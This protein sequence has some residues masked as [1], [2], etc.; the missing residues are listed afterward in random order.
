MPLVKA[1]DFF[2]EHHSAHRGGQLTVKELR[3]PIAVAVIDGPMV[4]AARAAAELH[5][6]PTRWVRAIVRRPP[7]RIGDRERRYAPDFATVDIVHRSI[8]ESYL[9]EH[10][11]PY[12]RRFFTALTKYQDYVLEGA[13]RGRARHRRCVSAAC[14]L[15]RRESGTASSGIEC[16]FRK[17]TPRGG[18]GSAAGFAFSCAGGA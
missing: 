3:L 17:G 10:V 7:D 18:G 14:R 15:P 1:T 5:V 16:L 6:E 11:V 13:A 12:V 2:W 4:L 8:F 9:D